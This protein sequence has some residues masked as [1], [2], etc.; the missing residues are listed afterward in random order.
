MPEKAFDP[1]APMA[2]FDRRTWDLVPELC[3][4]SGPCRPEAV[5]AAEKELDMTFGYGLRDCLLAYGAIRRG[6]VAFLDATGIVRVTSK[7]RATHGWTAGYAAIRDPDSGKC[8]MCDRSDRV[9]IA[10]LA[11]GG[12]KTTNKCV[13]EYAS[14]ELGLDGFVDGEGAPS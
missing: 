10:D 12:F 5:T 4:V 8:A 1:R 3:Q 2:P 13:W 14:A 6:N 11:G 9:Y 7:L